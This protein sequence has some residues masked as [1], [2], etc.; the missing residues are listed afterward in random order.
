MLQ[1]FCHLHPLILWLKEVLV[2][3]SDVCDYIVLSG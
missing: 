2:L 1:M 3:V